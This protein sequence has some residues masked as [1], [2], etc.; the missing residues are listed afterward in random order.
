M[1]GE[2]TK[3]G[4]GVVGGG[5]ALKANPGL[6]LHRSMP[7]K[8]DLWRP[9][10][11][12][13]PE[14]LIDSREEVIEGVRGK[15]KTY[16]LAPLRR[17]GPV[18]RPGR[19]RTLGR[20]SLRPCLRSQRR[21]RV[22]RRVRGGPW[23][24]VEGR[25]WGFGGREELADLKRLRDEEKGAKSRRVQPASSSTSYDPLLRQPDTTTERQ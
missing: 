24:N 3:M 2:S 1:K 16:R 25:V 10:L 20:G 5:R 12:P 7:L 22:R 9:S 11:V 13:A 21:P 4:V 17:R 6:L 15:L 14:G 8:R 19:A 23:E 18:R